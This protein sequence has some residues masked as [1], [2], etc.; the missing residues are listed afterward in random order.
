M[1]NLFDIIAVVFVTI[2]V[3]QAAI[4]ITKIIINRDNSDVREGSK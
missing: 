2:F 1:F 3:C 4:E